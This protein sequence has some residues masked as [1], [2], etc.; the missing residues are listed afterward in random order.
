M[1]QMHETSWQYWEHAKL[2]V[3]MKQHCSDDGG[4]R[5]WR[6]DHKDLA[7]CCQQ[8]L[9]VYFILLGNQIIE[10]FQAMRF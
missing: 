8:W 7:L 2:K 6:P 4:K 5:T 10:E 9:Q 3:S 1:I